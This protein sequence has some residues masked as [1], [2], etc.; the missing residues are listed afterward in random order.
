MEMYPDKDPLEAVE[1]W[2]QARDAKRSKAKPTIKSAAIDESKAKPT[3]KSAAID[4]S[5]AKPTIKSA[6][7][8]ESKAK[9]AI[10]SAAIATEK[11]PKSDKKL[12]KETK[13]RRD[14]LKDMNVTNILSS[15]S[16]RARRTAKYTETKEDDD[17]SVKSY[18]SDEASIESD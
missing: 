4:E 5:K 1:L 14:A 16:K 17:F 12:A 9:P 3:I 6:A 18:S 11:K 2:R 8:D 7:I 10:K 13:K 15:G